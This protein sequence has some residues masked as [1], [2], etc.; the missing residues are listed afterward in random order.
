MSQR[1]SSDRQQQ[2]PQYEDQKHDINWGVGDVPMP[3]VPNQAVLQ[4]LTAR[5][6]KVTLIILGRSMTQLCIAVLLFLW[7][8]YNNY[9][10][11]SE[12]SKKILLENPEQWSPRELIMAETLLKKIFLEAFTG[13]ILVSRG[14]R[15]Y[16]FAEVA[17]K[18]VPGSSYARA[19]WRNVIYMGLGILILAVGVWDTIAL[20]GVL[21][22]RNLITFAMVCRVIRSRYV[23]Y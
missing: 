19:F 21:P 7:M 3:L 10:L 16:L 14:L 17:S 20:E 6:L 23:W 18:V 22:W 2:P 5:R 9:C 11:L 12:S 15:D 8:S 13:T 1:L 4:T